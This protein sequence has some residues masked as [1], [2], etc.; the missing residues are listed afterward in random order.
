[1]DP[2]YPLGRG[3]LIDA[4]SMLIHVAQMTRPSEIRRVHRILVDDNHEPFGGAP[5][6]Q[7]RSC[8]GFVGPRGGRTGGRF[9][10]RAKP[11]WVLRRGQVVAETPP[12]VSQVL[13]RVS[14]ARSL[15]PRAFISSSVTSSLSLAEELVVQLG[16]EEARTRASLRLTSGPTPVGEGLLQPLQVKQAS[17]RSA[18]GSSAL[19]TAR[20]GP[21]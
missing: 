7:R 8:S 6:L 5:T 9:R 3:H 1:M 2:W 10:L 21:P 19:A 15:R 11:R 17:G 12:A 20:G 18:P 4:A 16:D 13:G 14:Q